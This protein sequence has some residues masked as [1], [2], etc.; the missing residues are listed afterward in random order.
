MLREELKT[1]RIKNNY[2]QSLLAKV[3]GVTT[4]TISRWETGA[5]EI[6]PFLHLTLKCIKKKGGGIKVG[7]PAMKKFKKERR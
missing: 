2:S 4:T 7:R 1:W 5:R 6:P 3:L